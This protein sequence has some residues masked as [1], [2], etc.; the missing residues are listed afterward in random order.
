MKLTKKIFL[1]SL[2]L[3]GSMQVSAQGNYKRDCYENKYGDKIYLRRYQYVY[4]PDGLYS[5]YKKEADGEERYER[6]NNCYRSY[7]WNRK[8][9][10]PVYRRA[11]YGEN[12]WGRPYLYYKNDGKN[13]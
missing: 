10:Y 5:K 12:A 3:A 1:F 8:E 6:I 7:R 4:G 11:N 13:D 2:M 9:A